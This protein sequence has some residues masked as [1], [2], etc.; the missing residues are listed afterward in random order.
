[1]FCTVQLINFFQSIKH[2]AL[3]VSYL[4][5]L[6]LINRQ[7]Y[8]IEAAFTLKKHADLLQWTDEKLE[9][10]HLVHSQLSKHCGTH[11]KLKERLYNEIADLF[12]EGEHWELAIEVRSPASV[13]S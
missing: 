3:Y 11:M 13:A 9:K 2:H 12:D 5:H 10:Y 6:Y 7:R 4:Y 8:Q 1:M